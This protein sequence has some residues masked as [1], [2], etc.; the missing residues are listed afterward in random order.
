MPFYQVRNPFL[1]QQ[2]LSRCGPCISPDLCFLFTVPRL[3]STP[4]PQLWP[5]RTLT[6]HPL[7][8]KLSR[9]SDKVRH[10]LPSITL[11]ELLRLL[12][13]SARVLHNANH[14]LTL[15]GNE[16]QPRDDRGGRSSRALTQA[17]VENQQVHKFM[18]PPPAMIQLFR[19][20][21][22]RNTLREYEPGDRSPYFPR[23]AT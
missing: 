16:S 22:E 9:Y 10:H 13:S 8:R 12:P 18:D 3:S 1:F 4:D 21:L 19:L 15:A 20:G 23:P 11:L 5:S 14:Q 6:D 17:A 7:Q 2:P